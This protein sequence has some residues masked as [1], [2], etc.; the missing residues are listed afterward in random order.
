MSGSV[1]LPAKE[2]LGGLP[3]FLAGLLRSLQI[4][5][6]ASVHKF[7]D[8]GLVVSPRVFGA[9]QLDLAV[10]FSGI[11]V[12]DGRRNEREKRNF[13]MSSRQVRFRCWRWPA[14]LFFTYR[15][16]HGWGCFFSMG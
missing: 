10:L 3:D 9:G 6:G 15:K 2:G 4:P 13:A 11:S 5:V 1:W 16:P 14:A 12:Y 8:R 7:S